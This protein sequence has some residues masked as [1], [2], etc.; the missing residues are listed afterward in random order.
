MKAG[1]GISV[2]PGK[3]LSDAPRKEKAQIQSPLGK[4]A[5]STGH[6]GREASDRLFQ[7]QPG[8]LAAI[9]AWRY[10]MVLDKNFVQPLCFMESGCRSD[11]SN[12]Q[13]RSDEQFDGM[14]D[15][16]APYFF[17]NAVADDMAEA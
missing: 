6:G 10:F 7:E 4:P 11:L 9:T 13:I 3:N 1:N 16:L 17:G 5:R 8:V 15:S 12:R 14:C 2:E